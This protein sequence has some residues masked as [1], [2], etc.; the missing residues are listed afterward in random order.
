MQKILTDSQLGA[1]IRR[2]R[3]SKIMSQADVVREQEL[4]GSF[5][6]GVSLWIYRTVS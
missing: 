4:K 5:N 6:V 2:V 1:N 3:E